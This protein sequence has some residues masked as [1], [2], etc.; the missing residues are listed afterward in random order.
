VVEAQLSFADAN[1]FNSG[2]ACVFERDVDGSEPWRQVAKLT[3]SDA[4]KGVAVRWTTA[5]EADTV[6]FQVL[7]EDARRREKALHPVGP[8]VPALGSE[9]EGGSY[10]LVDDSPEAAKATVYYIEDIDLFG[11]VTRHGPILVPRG[12]RQAPGPRVDR[13][14]PR[15]R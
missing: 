13:G 5:L 9:V 15:R 10:D 1:G 11:R 6:G 12:V 3:A 2:A 7:R 14:Q 4:A 8:I